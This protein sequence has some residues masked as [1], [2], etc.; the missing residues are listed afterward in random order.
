MKVAESRTKRQRKSHERGATGGR[1]SDHGSRKPRG[2]FGVDTQAHYGGDMV[3]S[4][5]G[6]WHLAPASADDLSAERDARTPGV[7]PRA[8]ADAV[9][10]AD[11]KMGT[12]PNEL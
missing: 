6:A 1:N 7:C 12:C 8:P 2:G 11:R 9:R 3:R 5:S 10:A 4:E